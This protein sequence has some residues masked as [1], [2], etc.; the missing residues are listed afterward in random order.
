MRLFCCQ[1]PVD[2]DNTI[3]SLS[4]S[5]SFYTTCQYLGLCSF[6]NEV[7]INCWCWRGQEKALAHA[8]HAVKSTQPPTKTKTKKTQCNNNTSNTEREREREKF[9]RSGLLPPKT[10]PPIISHEKEKTSLSRNRERE[11]NMLLLG[12][13]SDQVKS[14]FFLLVCVLRCYWR[15]SDDSNSST[16]FLSWDKI[17]AI[18]RIVNGVLTPLT[19]DATR[20][21]A[22]VKI[23]KT[24]MKRKWRKKKEKKKEN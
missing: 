6:S 19:N 5:L 14:F 21:L 13:L 23:S 22:V 16:S 17:E 7:K 9:S 15:C 3:V 1:A 20:N 2:W 4:L 10:R 8:R 11:A 12:Q 24:K 18:K